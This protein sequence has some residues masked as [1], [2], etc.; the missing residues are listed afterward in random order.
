MH[1][2]ESLADLNAYKD[3]GFKINLQTVVNQLIAI[4]ITQE[5]YIPEYAA[6][7]RTEEN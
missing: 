1:K 3:L 7:D 6:L 4:K 5:K 2:Q